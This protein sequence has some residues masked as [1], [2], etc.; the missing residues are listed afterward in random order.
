MG[1]IPDLAPRNQFPA[2]ALAQSVQAFPQ[3]DA[4][5]QGMVF[6]WNIASAADSVTPWGR[7]VAVRDRQLRD[8]WP[9]EPY[10]A[11]AQ[12]SVSFR[13]ATLQWEIKAG[14][15]KI[16]QAVT[17]ILNTALAGDGFGWVPFITKISQDLYTQ[18]NGAFIELIRDPGADANSKFGGALAPVLGIG[19]LDANRC[20]R[21]G[22]PEYPVVYTDRKGVRHKLRWYEVIAFA[23]YP[24]AIETMN[25]VGYC[26]VTR[27][28]RMAQIARSIAIFRDEKIS[29]RHYK[30]IHF[31]SGVSRQDI[32]DEMTRGQEEANNSG[33]IRFIMPSI[34]ASLDPEKPVSTA[35]IDLASLPDG[36]NFDEDMK[37]YIACLALGYG[38]DYQEFA[39]LPGGNIGSSQQSM[40]L[41]RKGTGKGPAM[42]M[43]MISDAF[44][45][46]GVLP[47]GAEMRFQ[48]RDEQEE[49]E[50]QTVRTKAME[51]MAIAI[52]S[53]ALTPQAAARSLVARGIWSEKD[54]ASIPESFWAM[55]EQQPA[56]VGQPVGSRGGNT[57]V[58]D[59]KR[60]ETEKQDT[61]ENAGSKL[62]KGLDA[63]RKAV[64][65]QAEAPQE[66]NI[67]LNLP[68]SPAPVVKVLT[69]RNAG[70]VQEVERDG[71]G[72]IV[73]T[74]TV[75]NYDGYVI[76]SSATPGAPE[77]AGGVKKAA[78]G[79]I[80]INAPTPK[81]QVI[82]IKMPK[83][84]ARRQ[85]VVRD[86][87]GNIEYTVITEEYDEE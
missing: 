20:V 31:V 80:V 48:D 71:Q 11:G 38:T 21:T 7:N 2:P 56:G 18:D 16:E 23:D 59:V 5:G 57:I 51:E 4:P 33:M 19:H 65:G 55:F 28:L 24:S 58:E 37:W 60:Q 41:H 69:P 76:T 84:K 70:S 67:V 6:T 86:K 34:L 12:S 40:I 32:K 82:N 77:Q 39:P 30:Q 53:H 75:M 79:S 66:P 9:T 15:E 1:R 29:G 36:F 35:T 85:Q 64:Q 52:N 10:L 17:D 44:R 3:E 42:Y 27:V 72:N 22:N 62:R 61:S 46:Y 25:G 49:L 50:K 26:A 14:S 13:N 63:L 68:E 8:F 73:A 74:R 43:R 45:N 81:Q 87:Q 47:R 54:I 83:L 78:D